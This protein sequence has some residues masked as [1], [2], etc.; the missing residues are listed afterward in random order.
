MVSMRYYIPSA[1]PGS[2]HQ[3][4]QNSGVCDVALIVTAGCLLNEA[5]VLFTCT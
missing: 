3:K 1:F 5:T 4:Q 2:S